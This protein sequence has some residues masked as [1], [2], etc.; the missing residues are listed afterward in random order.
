MIRQIIIFLKLLKFCIEKKSWVALILLLLI[1]CDAFCEF[2]FSS[3]NLKSNAEFGEVENIDSGNW[4]EKRIWWKK[5]KPKYEEIVELIPEVKKSKEEI[6]NKHKKIMVVYQDLIKYLKPTKESVEKKISQEINVLAKQLE[7]EPTSLEEAEQN[8]FVALSDKKKSL[9]DLKSNLDLFISLKKEMDKAVEV[10]LP[11]QVNLASSYEE[12][13]FS[14]YEQIENL[15]DDKKAKRFYEIIENDVENTKSI[16]HYIN[17]PLT[18]FF[19]ESNIK[20]NQFSS[21]IKNLIQ[22]IEKKGINLIELPEKKEQ[23]ITQQKKFEEEE[24]KNQSLSFIQKFTA[25]IANFFNYIWS[26]IKWP[27]IG[28]K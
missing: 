4:Y 25:A 19:N 17:G 16:L 13:A 23:K 14:K 6:L 5:A 28:K 22:E 1:N 21:N 3:D 8:A 20:L 11:Q 2:K 27:F 7:K 24:K 15:L 10:I 12:N 9:D 18:A 26:L